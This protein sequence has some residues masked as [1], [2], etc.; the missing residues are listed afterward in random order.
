LTIGFLA[1]NPNVKDFENL[2]HLK[3]AKLF[4]TQITNQQL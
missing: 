4:K 3:S 1:E 2:S